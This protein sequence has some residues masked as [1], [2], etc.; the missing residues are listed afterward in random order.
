[1]CSRAENPILNDEEQEKENSTSPVPTTPIS[2]RSNQPPV[3][4]RSHPFETS[5]ENVPDY[6]YRKLFEYSMFLLLSMYFKMNYK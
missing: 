2:E 4:M 5:F 6:V 1:M 3:L